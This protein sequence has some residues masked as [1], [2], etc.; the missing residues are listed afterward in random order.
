MALAEALVGAD[1]ATCV[2]TG[3]VRKDPGFAELTRF[4]TDVEERMNRLMPAWTHDF[5]LVEV[6]TQQADHNH[7]AGEAFI[8]CAPHAADF[9]THE[10]INSIVRVTVYPR[11]SNLFTV[12]LVGD[13][14]VL[15]QVE[16]PRDPTRA[17]L[18]FVHDNTTREP[19]RRP[20][21]RSLNERA[22]EEVLVLLAFKDS[23]AQLVAPDGTA[24]IP[25]YSAGLGEVDDA[26]RTAGLYDVDDLTR[27][28]VRRLAP[29]WRGDTEELRRTAEDLASPTRKVR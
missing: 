17:E 6:S 29:T 9:L 14:S 7:A 1:R 8:Y 13:G 28:L 19:A 4:A 18:A 16:L 12:E 3:S 24:R 26:L 22:D 27:G 23:P 15:L 11:A 25:A 20:L 2:E 10:H 5:P 21:I